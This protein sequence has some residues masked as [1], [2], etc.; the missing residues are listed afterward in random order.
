MPKADRLIVGLGNPGPEYEHT[1]HNVGF[2][3]VDAVA[4]TARAAFRHDGRANAMVAQGRTRGRPLTL[5]KPLTF[6]NR[7]GQSVKHLVRRFSLSPRNLLVVYD[8]LNLDVGRLRLRERGSAGGHNGMQDIIDR[9]GT[10]DFPRLRLGIGSDYG[11]GQQSEY[12]LSPFDADQEPLID[13]ALD[14]AHDAVITFVTDGVVTA[15]NR[16]N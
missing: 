13:E 2:W 15:M 1:R 12:V 3:V 5:A 9:L 8:D 4:E 16:F 11:R 7:S 14:R 10:D 6:M